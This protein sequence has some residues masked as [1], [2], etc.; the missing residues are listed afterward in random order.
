MGEDWTKTGIKTAGFY[1]RWVLWS[2]RT[3]AKIKQ[4]ISRVS[5]IPAKDISINFTRYKVKK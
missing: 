1:S 4:N 5:G 2:D 3:N